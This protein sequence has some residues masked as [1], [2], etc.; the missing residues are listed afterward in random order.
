MKA[1]S[2]SCVLLILVNLSL[3][4]FGQNSPL[5]P[6]ERLEI[7]NRIISD[8]QKAIY[9][10]L[11][12]SR[13]LGFELVIEGESIKNQTTTHADK[14]SRNNVSKAKTEEGVTFLLPDQGS[15]FNKV[16]R[17]QNG[18]PFVVK[19]SS[20]FNGDTFSQTVDMYRDGKRIDLP[21]IAA[22]LPAN[23]SSATKE[24]ISNLQIKSSITQ[25]KESYWTLVYPLI[26]DAPWDSD[27]KPKY[28]FRG[29][30]KVGQTDCDL[31]ELVRNT[32]NKINLFFD[33]S[34]K[35]LVLMK[36]E[37]KTEKSK[38]MTSY[39]YSDYSLM[40]GMLI[41]NKINNQSSRESEIST[42]WTDIVSQT[43]QTQIKQKVVKF[44]LK[45]K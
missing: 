22:M 28:I 31:V 10:K 11:E 6:E 18:I 43:T 41:P 34:T 42:D 20:K 13:I 26:L 7:G 32:G 25:L 39:Y 33:Q 35:L 5:T 12:P 16:S 36:I 19:S 29:R 21:S 3:V 30:A 9:G 40:D 24:K 38:S 45:S 14:K 17:T 2:V 37:N 44:E 15:Q 1:Y 8:S 4:T 23:V 27:A